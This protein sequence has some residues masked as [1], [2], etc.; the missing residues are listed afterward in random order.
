MQISHEIFS[1]KFP[2]SLLIFRKRLFKNENLGDY[3]RNFMVS[4]A[5]NHRLSLSSS[6]SSSSSSLGKRH[7]NSE[8]P[9]LQTLS[10]LFHLVQFVKCWYFFLELTKREI[11]YFHVAVVR[12]RKRNVQKSVIY[13]H[14][15]CFAN[16]NLL[17]FC[18]SRWR[19]HRR[20]LSSLLPLRCRRRHLRRHRHRG[21]RRHCHRRHHRRCRNDF[22]QRH[23][24]VVVVTFVMSFISDVSR[25]LL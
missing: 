22:H 15:C 19:H 1:R 17:L 13:V 25:T 8:F 16:L 6:L 9:L 20:C 23:H 2:S 24:H 3:F 4:P 10:R 18:R 5:H 14:G 21:R 7:L 11:R 12:W